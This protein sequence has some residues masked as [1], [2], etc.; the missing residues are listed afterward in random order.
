MHLD[1]HYVE[2]PHHGDGG[3][4]FGAQILQFQPD[5]LVFL[6]VAACGERLPAAFEAPPP[7]V[8][9]ASQGLSAVSE[10]PEG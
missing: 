9:L 7:Y 6:G 3:G 1:A 4:Q 8:T 10:T 5:R 2:D